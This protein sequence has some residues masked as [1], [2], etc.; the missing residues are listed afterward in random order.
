MNYKLMDL[1]NIELDVYD[2]DLVET[3][4]QQELNLDTN[5]FLSKAF[6]DDIKSHIYAPNVEQWLINNFLKL[7]N[8]K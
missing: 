2:K 7:K 3:C 6:E 5:G 8:N 4:L 1:H